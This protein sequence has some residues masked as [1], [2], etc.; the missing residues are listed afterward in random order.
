MMAISIAAI[1]LVCCIAVFFWNR[2]ADDAEP[3][4]AES[5]EV[6]ASVGNSINKDVTGSVEDDS[7]SSFFTTL[8]NV[9]DKRR[10][11]FGIVGVSA[12]IVMPDNRS[13]VGVTGR[14]SE[15]ERVASDMLF[16]IG[17]VTKSYIAALLLKYSENGLL[18]LDNSIGRW[19]QDLQYIDS[20]ATVRQL[21]NHTSGIHNYMAHPDYITAMMDSPE[22][23]WSREDLL[24]S[25]VHVPV[26]RPGASWSYSATNYLLAG[27]I[28]EEV[29][30][31]PVAKEIREHLLEPLDLKNTYLYPDEEL[32]IE[33]M[34]HLWMVLD[35]T[36]VPVDVN[37]LMQDNPLVGAF[38]SV[39]T[40]G[41]IQATAL[42]AARWLTA[43]FR[44]QVLAE[45]SL[46]DMTTPAPESGAVKYGLGIM[47]EESDIITAYGHSGGLG[48]S[49]IV[50]Y[51][52]TDS[53]SIAVLCNSV[54]D[55]KPIAFDLYHVCAVERR[56][57]S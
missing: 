50:L 18:D 30:G 43:L 40:A 31:N 21:L 26:G 55:P 15:S 53:I 3:G 8:Q 16:G 46:K 44:G 49:S 41:A 12:A 14:S 37:A 35:T 27:M 13:W 34:A 4:T 36:G 52:P 10:S 48:Y 42:D 20:T 28:A 33:R 23:L 7:D 5:E 29:S 47:V 25:F 38:S 11:S 19:L 24:N 6:R 57:K 9:L 54:A 39:W 45:S 56:N 2:V 22:R 1:A 51:F 17:S 32:P